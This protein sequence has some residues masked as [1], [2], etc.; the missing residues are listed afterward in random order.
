MSAALAWAPELETTRP[1]RSVRASA[2]S[3]GALYQGGS[4]A[5]RL[6]GWR[7]PTTSANQAIQSNIV[8]LRDRS[9]AATRNDGYAKSV[10]DKLV[11]NLIGTGIKPLSQ[12]SDAGLRD[13]IHALFLRWT[14]ES[15]ADG[16]LD[17]YGQ[18]AQAVRGWKEAGECFVRLRPRLASDGLSVPLQLQI[19]EPE[20]CPVHHNTTLANGNRVRMGIELNAVGRRLAYWFHPSRP[21][22][23]EDFDSSQLVRVPASAIIHLYDP[24]RAGQL[25]G[26]PTLTPALIRLFE[27]DKFDD[28][29]LLRQQLQNMVV[30]FLKKDGPQSESV[31][32]LTG[33][34]L[35]SDGAER[36]ALRMNPGTFQELEA[37]EEVQFSDPPDVQGGYKEFMRQQLYAIAA[38]TGVP[39]EVFTGDL[40]GLNDRIVRV[41]LNEFRR[42][43]QADQHQIIAFQLC[44]RVYREWMDRAF[45]VDALPLPS[46]YVIDP[47]PFTRAKWQPQG[48]PYLHPVQD[49]EA[50]EKAI[51]DGFASRS[52]VVSMRG[53]DAEV[54]DAENAADNARADQLGLRYD[55]DGRNAKKAAPA[56]QDKTEAATV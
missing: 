42:K 4:Q 6:L 1:V 34:P 28:A 40:S 22:E 3:P 14:D 45:L 23:F 51:R 16:I 27:L 50:D 35:S 46:S 18:Q 13:Q 39:F 19:V 53:E 36:P 48:W 21:T 8:T 37:G 52:G 43:L 5:R 49:V 56:A 33:Q 17:F 44:R 20:L 32:P 31:H 41:I 2:D 10:I 55:S 15:D 7:A 30:W 11:S 25:R 24:L 47:E 54:I 9:R 29:T 38:A 26:V 12:V